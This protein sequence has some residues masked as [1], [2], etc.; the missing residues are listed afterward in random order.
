MKI[1]VENIQRSAGAAR[2]ARP[3]GVRE[4]APDILCFREIK[5]RRM[6]LPRRNF[7]DLGLTTSRQREKA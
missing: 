4:A 5:K 7:E 1:A 6:L 2:K 3:V